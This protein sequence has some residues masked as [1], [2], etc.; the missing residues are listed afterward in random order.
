MNL[1]NNST[2]VNN[3]VQDQQWATRHLSSHGFDSISTFSST[4]SYVPDLRRRTDSDIP[5]ATVFGPR[6]VALPAATAAVEDVRTRPLCGGEELNKVRGPSQ[7]RDII[8]IAF[9]PD[10]VTGD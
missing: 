1:S 6:S 7:D 2:N 9:G 3:N 4:T 10:A 8:D 5:S